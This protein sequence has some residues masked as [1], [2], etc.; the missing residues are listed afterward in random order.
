MVLR[1]I[2]ADRKSGAIAHP[3]SYR[4]VEQRTENLCV[5]VPI[6]IGTIPGELNQL[7]VFFLTMDFICYI[8]HSKSMN[9]YYVGHTSDFG[10]R[11]KMHNDGHFGGKTYTRRAKDWEEF[12]LITCSTVKLAVY[13]E[14][15][16]KRMKSR[17]YIE[18]LKKY[19]EL[20][21]KIIKEFDN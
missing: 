10:E 9:R 17:K 18:N 13:L 6:A 16:I 19:P 3:D 8:I 2:F 1:F 21:D 15:K 4:E 5:P 12:L 20:I 14:L 7:I 11:I